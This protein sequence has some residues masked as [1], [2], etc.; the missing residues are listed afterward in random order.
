MNDGTWIPIDCNN[1]G[2]S[3]ASVPFVVPDRLVLEDMNVTCVR[4]QQSVH[5]TRAEYEFQRIAINLLYDA[6]ITRQQARRFKR[7]VEKSDNTDH[8]VEKS[9]L[10]NPAFKEVSV[11]AKADPEPKSAFKM[12]AKVAAFLAATAATTV[13]ADDLWDRYQQQELF[14]NAPSQ[15]IEKGEAGAPEQNGGNPG[16]DA[17]REAPPKP[18]VD[19]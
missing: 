11:I 10:I 14:Q 16:A 17:D 7:L 19:V 3:A 6:G 12:L 1:C 2:A 18:G 8:I 5:I 4:C 13:V 9:E 15:R